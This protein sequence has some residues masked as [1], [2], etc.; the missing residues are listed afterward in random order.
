MAPGLTTVTAAD[1]HLDAN[2]RLC[3]VIG[4]P[5]SHSLSPHMHNAAFRAAGLNFAYL[6]FQ[7]SDVGGFLAGMRAMPSFRGCSVTIPHKQAVMSHLDIID[8]NAEFVGSVN[9]VTRE[10][11]GRLVGHSTDGPGTLRAFEDAGVALEGRRVVF[12]GA[13]GAVRAVAFAFASEGRVGE[14]TLL[15]RDVNKAHALATEITAKTGVPARGGHLF[16]DV[17]DAIVAAEVLVQGTP[18]GMVPDTD[19]TCIPAESLHRDLTVFDMVYR[20]H[21]TRLL[22]D[23]QVAGCAVIHGI[24][25]LIA[26]AVLQWERWTGEPCPV[27]AMRQAALTHLEGA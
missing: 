11:D 16:E 13:G 9:T 18:I 24:E 10:P 19:T 25:M 7:V 22:R 26:Q 23:A 5:V 17:R 1:S 4:N 3:A 27:D 6:A 8:P 12:T 2:T 15:G 14:I 21:E 20:P